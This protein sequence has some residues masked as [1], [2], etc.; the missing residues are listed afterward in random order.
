[1]VTFERQNIMV[2][3][4]LT[5]TGQRNQVRW[6]W[7]CF[8]RDNYTPRIITGK[9]LDTIMHAVKVDADK[10]KARG[11]ELIF[12]RTPSN[13]PYLAEENKDY[14]RNKYWDRLLA[15]TGCKGIHFADHPVISKLI[16]PE[17]SH[18]N[19]TDAII[20]T[21]NLISILKHDAGWKFNK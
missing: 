20:Y 2:D 6:I 9:A 17:Y 1:M 15:I 16:C 12:L 7:M 11:G 18:L 8:G 21:Q 13:G 5:D 3:K 19:P 14:P 4:F 10:I